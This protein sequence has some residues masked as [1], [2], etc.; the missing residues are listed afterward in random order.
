MM[1]EV[2]S[3]ISLWLRYI[4][5]SAAYCWQRFLSYFEHSYM[6]NNIKTH[7]CLLN[8]YECRDICRSD[9]EKKSD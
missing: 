3:S 2:V 4:K 6:Y 7:F 1:N 8:V 5:H 9:F